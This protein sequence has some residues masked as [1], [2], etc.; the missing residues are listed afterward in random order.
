MSETGSGF[1]VWVQGF[2][3]RIQL[4]FYAPGAAFA[5]V[6]GRETAQDWLL[7][8]LL[9]CLVGL[10]AHQL[11]LDVLTDLEAPA[12]QRQLESMS[13]EGRQRYEQSTAML[14][15]HG[16][17]TIPV[18]TF[19]SLVI[20]GG[21]LMA[22]A[23]SLFLVEVNYRQM[24]VVRAYASSVVAVEWILQAALIWST[25]DPG[26]HFGFGVLLSDGIAAS[27]VG[28]VLSAVNPFDLWQI[29]IMGVGLSTMVDVPKEKA[30]IA[31]VLLWMFWLVGGVGVET[32]SRNLPPPPQG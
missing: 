10:A 15:A 11:T 6:R 5:A 30:L 2:F 28:R 12:A 16:W 8:T 20:V 31:I 26:V 13:E 1:A 17:M 32:I 22:M 7:P 21:V 24:L 9:V 14:R 25:G 19:T 3:E 27:F 23:R 4:I 29:G 18:G